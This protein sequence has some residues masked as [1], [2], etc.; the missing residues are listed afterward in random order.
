V[1]PRGRG[2]G[3]ERWAAVTVTVE[4]PRGTGSEMRRWHEPVDAS[5]HDRA[6][7]LGVGSFTARLFDPVGED[8][9]KED[10][11]DRAKE[12]IDGYCVRCPVRAACYREGEKKKYEGVWGGVFRE[13]RGVIDTDTGMVIRPDDP[14]YS[15][16]PPAAK[17]APKRRETPAAPAW[18]TVDYEVVETRR[19]V[20]QFALLSVRDLV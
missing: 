1:P 5:W 12:A 16:P 15:A 14:A 10:A 6:A 4:R 2:P 19:G 18:A 17:P 13:R 20:E 7:C 9:D 3:P 8:E 11:W